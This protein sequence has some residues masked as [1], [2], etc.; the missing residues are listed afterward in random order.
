LE[1]LAGRFASHLACGQ[2]TQFIVNQGKQLVGSGIAGLG[3]FED[4]GHIAHAPK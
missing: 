4:A 3:A 2:P 1:R